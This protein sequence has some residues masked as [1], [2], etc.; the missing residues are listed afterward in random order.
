M[1]PSEI[2][3]RSAWLPLVVLLSGCAVF[4]GVTW[5]GREKPSYSRTTAHVPGPDPKDE[6]A[7][8]YDPAA[9]APRDVPLEGDF[10][11]AYREARKNLAEKNRPDVALVL[12]SSA[13][14]STT[15]G[16][17]PPPGTAY[18]YLLRGITYA[19]QQNYGP[20]NRDLTEAIRLDPNL[21]QAYF[22]RSQILTA[23]KQPT[24]AQQDAE[25]GKK[26]A[27]VGAWITC[28][29]NGAAY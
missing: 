14:S 11:T 16:E 26:I 3:C 7:F 5:P 10:Q 25:Q 27:P 21:W 2:A 12:L 28:S 23:M 22:H 15:P 4:D 24:L 13:L 20:A 18:L 19:S 6:Q 9:M 8:R 17:A 1:S 29:P